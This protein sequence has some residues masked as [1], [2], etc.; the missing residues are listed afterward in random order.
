[1]CTVKLAIRFNAP[2]QKNPRNKDKSLAAKATGLPKA[3]S[4]CSAV[5]LFF[6]LEHVGHQNL[7]LKN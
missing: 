3:D 5:W 7:D 6:K 1:M 2:V 4:G